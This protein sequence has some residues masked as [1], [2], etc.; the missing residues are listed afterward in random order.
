VLEIGGVS[1][2]LNYPMKAWR[3]LKEEF[4]G[5]DGIQE[6]IQKN[7]L[8][9]VLEKF[10]RLVHIGTMDNKIT[11]EEIGKYLDEYNLNEMTNKILPVVMNAITG[12]LPVAKDN[13]VPPK[14]KTGK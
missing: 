6:M 5:L 13:A 14:A 9:F 12:T 3:V 4:G 10:P 1:I 8:D 7:T 11:V 2:P